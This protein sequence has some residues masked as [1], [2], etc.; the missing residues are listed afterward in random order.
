MLNRFS[1]DEGLQK[2]GTSMS[3]IPTYVTAVPN[4]TEKVNSSCWSHFMES[5][6]CGSQGTLPGSRP[7]R[8]KLQSLLDTIAWEHY[9][10]SDTIKSRHTSR[11]NDS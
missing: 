5:A 10:L 2:T 8:D 3:Q 1:I 9:F 6:D 11:S 7:R 4:G